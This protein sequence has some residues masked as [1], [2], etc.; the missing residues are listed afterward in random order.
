MTVLLSDR[1][2]EGYTSPALNSWADGLSGGQSRSAKK[3]ATGQ[4]RSYLPQ[5]LAA[6][7]VFGGKISRF[8][9]TG[10][11]FVHFDFHEPY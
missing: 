10:T 2:A 7:G 6:T 5:K 11:L 3:S 4:C 9:R 8:I 1:Q